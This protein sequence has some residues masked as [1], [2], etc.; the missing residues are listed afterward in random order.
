MQF[1][2]VPSNSIYV[3]K[4]TRSFLNFDTPDTYMKINGEWVWVVS[5][6]Y[7]VFTV[8]YCELSIENRK[9]FLDFL[10]HSTIAYFKWFYTWDSQKNNPKNLARDVNKQVRSIFENTF[11]DLHQ[12]VLNGLGYVPLKEKCA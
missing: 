3:K 10:I 1:K 11:G 4:Y 6:R 12:E 5:G 7:G 8:D 2:L 9:R